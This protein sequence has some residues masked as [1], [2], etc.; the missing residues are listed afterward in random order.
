MLPGEPSPNHT[1]WLVWAL[2]GEGI[3]FVISSVVTCII[4]RKKD[5]ELKKQIEQHKSIRSRPVSGCFCLSDLFDFDQVG[6]TRAA[7]HGTA[8]DDDAIALLQ[9]QRFDGDL[10]GSIEQ[11]VSRGKGLAHGGNNTP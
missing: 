6:V 10:F 8:R 3:A 4:V 2:V 1:P 11:H 5:K 7:R 9:G